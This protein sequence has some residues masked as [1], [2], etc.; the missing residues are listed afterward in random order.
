[1]PR[2]PDTAY[3]ALAPDWLCEIVSPSTAAIDRVK[4]L[5]IY[6]REGAGHVWFI[7]PIARTLEVLGLHDGRW[8]I[9]ATHA[10]AEVVRAEP[11]EAVELNLSVLWD[12][13]A[14]TTTP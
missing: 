10:G 8:I 11:F 2:L 12:E 7:D 9:A 1:M 6:A 5:V 13:S 14:T 4:K 3:F